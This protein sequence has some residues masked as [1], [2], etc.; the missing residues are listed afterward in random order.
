MGD[1]WKCWG[2]TGATCDMKKAGNEPANFA[3][4]F[5]F[6]VF[7]RRATEVFPRQTVMLAI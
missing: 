7:M 6:Q 3:F 2:I 1:R 5:C 4:V